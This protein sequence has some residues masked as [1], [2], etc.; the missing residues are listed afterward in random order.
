MQTVNEQS[1][2]SSDYS[3]SSEQSCDTV[4]YRGPDGRMLSDNELTDNE[5][6]PQF[7]RCFFSYTRIILTGNQNNLLHHKQFKMQ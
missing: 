3:S 6:P 2:M 5:R 4:I 1:Y 7:S